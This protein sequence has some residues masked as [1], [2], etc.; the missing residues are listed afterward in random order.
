[1]P[2]MKIE[3]PHQLTEAEAMRR[4]QN[5][6]TEIKRDYGDRVT[7]LQ[8]SWTDSGGT[9]S[10]RAMGFAVSGILRSKPGVVELNGD[11]PLAARPFKGKIEGM[12]RERAEQL[13][14][15]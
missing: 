4:I 6:L 12:I 14:A 7:D 5:L 11:Y 15:G 1:M 9:F 3:V 2:S 8:E 13:L 10:F